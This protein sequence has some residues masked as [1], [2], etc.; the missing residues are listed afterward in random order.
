MF[1]SFEGVLLKL[2]YF[3]QGQ[4]SKTFDPS[5]GFGDFQGWLCQKVAI[6]PAAAQK[7]LARVSKAT[8]LS[9]QKQQN[10]CFFSDK[11]CLFTEN[12]VNQP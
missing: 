3:V 8:Q 6:L 9:S 10:F 11:K 1:I 12:F 2:W 5:H 4:P 7:T